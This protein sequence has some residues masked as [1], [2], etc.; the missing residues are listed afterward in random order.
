M[1]QASTARMFSEAMFDKAYKAQGGH[2][3]DQVFEESLKDSLPYLD[4][5]KESYKPKRKTRRTQKMNFASKA[6][7]VQYVL[8]EYGDK[9]TAVHGTAEGQTE[10]EAA[11]AEALKAMITTGGVDEE[12]EEEEVACPRPNFSG[13]NECGVKYLCLAL[14]RSVHPQH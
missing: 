2:G 13:S 14:F 5:L 4:S 9:G 12:D 6:A 1:R 8:L 7:H 3:S 10:E 11:A